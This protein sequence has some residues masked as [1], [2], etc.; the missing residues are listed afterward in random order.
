MPAYK[1]YF[2][3]IPKFE[4]SRISGVEFGG[5]LV[6]K[7]INSQ[8]GAYTGNGNPNYANSPLPADKSKIPSVSSPGVPVWDNV[9][10]PDAMIA[11]A[12]RGKGW[13]LMT[14][15]EQAS[16]AYLAKE[17]NIQPTGNT[18]GASNPPAAYEDSTQVGIYD[19]ELVGR[20]LPGTGTLKWVQNRIYDLKGLTR[21][22]TMMLMASSN[23]SN[24]GSL[25][26]PVN[27]DTTY[28]GSPFG[29]AIYRTNSDENFERVYMSNTDLSGVNVG[30]SVEDG[31]GNASGYI[32]AIDDSNDYVY[33][34]VETDTFANK[35]EFHD[36]TTGI[37]LTIDGSAGTGA[38]GIDSLVSIYCN[39]SS[40]TV[41]D[42]SW[43]RNQFVGKEAYIAE[44][45]DF[46]ELVTVHANTSAELIFDPT[47]NMT[48]NFSTDD[49]ATFC[50]MDTISASNITSPFSSGT[51]YSVGDI[52]T[53]SDL[54]PFAVI[55]ESTA[56]S[57]IYGGQQ[58]FNYGGTP[59]GSSDGLYVGCQLGGGY[60][61]QDRAGLFMKVFNFTP[62]YSD[63]L[64]SFR[65]TKAL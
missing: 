59:Q 37:T 32:M 11:C 61:D 23:H 1:S 40:E 45:T 56:E 46:G 10:L 19:G 25:L 64:T 36:T 5:F 12:N 14:P 15:F 57:S 26:V 30:D 47:S 20:A 55:A 29:R 34:R 4:F 33:V 49:L 8:P 24:P 62:D 43:T 65:A 41:W 18:A 38:T 53:N 58:Y 9:S 13:H 63:N 60:T 35:D 2:S 28:Q 16:L 54:G 27:N 3:F 7:F 6:D 44:S 21:E 17:F 22:W 42:K 52:Y 50:I 48:S 39:N 51:W 31:V